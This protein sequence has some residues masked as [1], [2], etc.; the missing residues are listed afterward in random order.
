MAITVQVTG[1]ELV[2][3]KLAGIG[4]ECRAKLADAMKREWFLLQRHVV[5]NKLSG[6]V[7][8][9]RTGNLASSINVGGLNSASEFVNGSTGDIIG[10]V[11]TK[12]VYGAVHEYGGSVTIKAH[13][14][15]VT[16]VYGRA[17]TPTV[18]NVRSYTMRVPERSF[19]RSSLADRGD[20]IRDNVAS[21]LR[22]FLGSGG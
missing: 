2:A 3:T 21:A 6:Q 1:T 12:V 15:R 5:S 7:L 13:T 4:Q 11:G 18:A 17:V 9:R 19:L 10:R 20:Q 14:R 22:D 16:Q 8:K